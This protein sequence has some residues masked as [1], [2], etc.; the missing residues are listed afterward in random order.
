MS[1]SEK[2]AKKVPVWDIA[3]R[4]FHWTLVLSIPVMWLLAENNFMDLHKTL[5][6]LIAGLVVFRLTWGIWGST[7]ARFSHFIKGPRAIFG[8]LGK[9]GQPDYKP[10]FGHNP[11]GALAVFA[12]IAALVVQ[13]GA[14][15]FAV[16]TDGMNSGPLSR[17][18]SFEAGRQASDIHE[19]SFNVLVGLIVLHILA[20]LFYRF[21]KRANLIT[22]MITGKMDQSGS[23]TNEARLKKPGLIALFIS[24]TLAAAAVAWLYSV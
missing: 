6:I 20:I 2:P 18:V 9:L 13:I 11:L 12:M 23:D 3:T 21:I 1:R 7:T 17:F 19:L 16:D 4:L 15:L 24:L 14:G 5:G 10:S 8:Y 22:P